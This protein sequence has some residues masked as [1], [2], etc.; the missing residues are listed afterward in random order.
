MVYDEANLSRSRRPLW[1]EL[2]V[3]IVVAGYGRRS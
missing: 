2:R 3:S 1:K